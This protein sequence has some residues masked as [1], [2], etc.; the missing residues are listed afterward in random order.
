MK[1]IG[2]KVGAA[3]IRYRW[4]CTG[5]VAPKLAVSPTKATADVP[6]VRGGRNDV[7]FVRYD[8]AAGVQRIRGGLHDLIKRDPGHASTQFKALCVVE[9]V[10]H[11]AGHRPLRLTKGDDLIDLDGLAVRRD[12][13]SALKSPTC[14]RHLT[15]D[16]TPGPPVG[17]IEVPHLSRDVLWAEAARQS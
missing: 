17:L 5:L 3:S 6:S 15:G 11:H 7:S 16:D 13:D 10:G 12:A 2:P 9:R 1:L 4:P 14:I 8:D